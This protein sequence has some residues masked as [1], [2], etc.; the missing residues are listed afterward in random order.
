M[1]RYAM[2]FTV[3]IIF[4]Y[5]HFDIHSFDV[6]YYR[7]TYLAPERIKKSISGP[8]PKKIVHHWYTLPNWSLDLSENPFTHN[9]NC[10]KLV[11]ILTLH[12]TYGC[13]CFRDSNR[14]D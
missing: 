3:N 7:H 9:L 1:L 11:M 10:H 8:R 5:I 4:I 12:V 6:N 2:Y 14:Y 13:H